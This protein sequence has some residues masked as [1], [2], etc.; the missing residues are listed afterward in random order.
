MGDLT[1]SHRTHGPSAASHDPVAGAVGKQTQVQTSAA[2]LPA[3]S[4]AIAIEAIDAATQI[5]ESTQSGPMHRAPS[6]V[7]GT[8]MQLHSAL[9]GHSVF[10]PLGMTTAARL[11]MF[12]TA[13]RALAPCAKVVAA[14]RDGRETELSERFTRLVA[15]RRAKLGD[16]AGERRVEDAT[17]A[18]ERADA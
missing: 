17:V 4:P 9:T 6:A 8:L 16:G 15:D 12:D 11:E 3:A 10:Y 1:K 18:A 7:Y 14:Q 2:A 13:I 5:L